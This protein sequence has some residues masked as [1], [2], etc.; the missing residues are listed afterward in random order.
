MAKQNGIIKLKGT[1]GDIAFYKSKDGHL[2]REKGGIDASRIKSDAA[3]QRT[4]ENMNEFALAGK[5]GKMI[6]M[7]FRTYLVYIG[8]SRVISRLVKAMFDVIKADLTS[9]RGQR[10]VLDG[11]LE[12]L[13]GF[14]FNATGN[15]ASSVYAPYTATI[16]RATGVLQVSIPAF[17]PGNMI[18]APEGTTHIR[19]ISGGASIDFEANT[20]E[21]ATSQSDMIA[22]SPGEV[23][24]INLVNQLGANS[25]H[26]LFLVLG[27]EFYQQVNGNNY[28]LK[29]GTYNALALVKVLGL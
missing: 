23:P 5:A 12:L 18:A 19:I 10:N 1:I 20:F 4:R 15:L 17:V 29:N 3:F 6:R 24:A 9:T 27:I 26:P 16:D 14:E 2:A 8:D 22:L 28:P 7:A 11:E 21:V 25:T 13:E